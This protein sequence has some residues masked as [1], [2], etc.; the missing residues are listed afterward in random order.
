MGFVVTPQSYSPERRLGW[1]I[2]VGLGWDRRRDVESESK[3]KIK[4]LS[5]TQHESSLLLQEKKREGIVQSCLTTFLRACD[6]I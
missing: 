6:K 4:G 3:N 1:A 5:G 2:R